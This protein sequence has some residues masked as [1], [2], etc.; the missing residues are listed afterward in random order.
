MW[1]VEFDA[2]WTGWSTIDRLTVEFAN[3][4]PTDTTVFLWEN[5][6]AYSLGTEYRWASF[7]MRG[8]YTYDVTPIPD[9]TVSPLLPDGNRQW[10]S[11]GVGTTGERWSLDAAYQLIL[12]DRVKANTFGSGFSSTVPPIDARANGH[13]WSHAH[14]VGVSAGYQ[15]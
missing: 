6:M 3:G 5:A 12:F 8:G 7:R 1:N 11:V 15:F 2:V 13:Y 4:R 10:W 14:V 9:G